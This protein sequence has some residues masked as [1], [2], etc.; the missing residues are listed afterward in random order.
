M[1]FYLR[2][3]G[4]ALKKLSLDERKRLWVLSLD[5]TA[6]TDTFSRGILLSLGEGIKDD[7]ED[8]EGFW[9]RPLVDLTLAKTRFIQTEGDSSC[10]AALENPVREVVSERGSPMGQPANW[11]FL[12]LFREF[13]RD[14]SR[15]LYGYSRK[16][17]L[18]RDEV[19]RII[20]DQDYSCLTS[21]TYHEEPLSVGCGDDDLSIM[22]SFQSWIFEE[23][24]VSFGAEI[25]KGSHFR[26][27]SYGTFTEI[28]Y[29]FFAK[30]HRLSYIDTVKIKSLTTPD[31]RLPGKKEVPVLWNRG[32][33]VTQGLK[34]LTWTEEGK[35]R[36]KFL[37]S[38]AFYRYFRF[39]NTLIAYG[40]P[41]HTPKALGGW[42]LDH[43]EGRNLQRSP[44]YYR[45]ALKVLFRNDQSLDNLLD[46]TSLASIWSPN[47][48]SP[49]GR[50]VWRS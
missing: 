13:C 31:S 17:N 11:I 45:R 47:A 12:N 44:G 15:S 4:T 24:L 23:I 49:P 6:A 20:R 27:R 22:R 35:L 36:R 30:N 1:G 29:E 50:S 25:S 43:Y 21:L 16:R 38:N 5:L 41:V 19:Q 32:S 18:P 42:G 48:Y 14:L 33:A 9:L 40:I 28:G 34:S 7:L 37:L 46:G 26:S 2:R 3:I 8:R 10:A 39:I